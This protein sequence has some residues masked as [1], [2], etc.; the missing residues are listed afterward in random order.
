MIVGTNINLNTEI[1]KS[2]AEYSKIMKDAMS[3]EYEDLD[4][5]DAQ[6]L[7]DFLGDFFEQLL[8]IGRKAAHKIDKANEFH[9]AVTPLVSFQSDLDRIVENERVR[10]RLQS[11]EKD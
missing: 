7:V 5:E 10:R 4:L 6:H 11:K 3:W 1:K 2:F 8:P 9:E